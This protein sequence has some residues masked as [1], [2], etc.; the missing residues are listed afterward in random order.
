MLGNRGN[1]VNHAANRLRGIGQFTHSLT[2]V[3]NR[4]GHVPNRQ[5]AVI[6]QTTPLLRQLVGFF[7][8][9]GGALYV[10][11][12]F[13]N[14]RRHLVDGRGRLIGLAALLIKRLGLAQ[15]QLRRPPGM[16]AHALASVGQARQGGLQAGFFAEH[17]QIELRLWATVV[18]VGQRDQ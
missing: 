3:S 16:L 11:R 2:D 13:L 8:S 17:G 6:S 12:H 7:G 1:H 4:I 10:V 14:G 5:Q 15:R 9:V 18:A